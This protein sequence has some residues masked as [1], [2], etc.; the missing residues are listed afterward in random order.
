MTTAT[1]HPATNQTS[2]RLITAFRVIALAEAISWG[3]LLIAMLFK[4]ALIENE[5]GVKVVG[6][7]HGGI[8][9][10][11]LIVTIAV[12]VRCQWR[13]KVTLLGLF[14][15]IPPFMTVVFEKWAERTGLLRVPGSDPAV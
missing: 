13:P 8:F 9:I 1:A 14:S 7:I 5:V 3:A 12:S 2:D 6:P 4:Y 11:F 10:A 15:A